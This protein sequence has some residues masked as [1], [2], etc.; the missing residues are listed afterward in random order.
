MLKNWVSSTT[1]VTEKCSLKIG[2]EIPNLHSY[3][4]DKWHQ[5]DLS[6]KEITSLLEKKLR[7]ENIGSRRLQHVGSKTSILW[8]SHFNAAV[9]EKIRNRFDWQHRFLDHLNLQWGKISLGFNDYITEG[10]GGCGGK[11]PY[12]DW[13]SFKFWPLYHRRN[14]NQYP[15]DGKHAGMKTHC[16]V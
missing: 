14:R 10:F 5:C 12:T 1:A 16:Y 7:N 6:A 4:S 15:L 3:K 11:A 9:I 8:Y 13:F 2:A